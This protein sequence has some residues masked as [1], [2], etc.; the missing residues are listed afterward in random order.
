VGLCNPLGRVFVD[1]EEEMS[2]KLKAG[3]IGLGILGSKH[4]QALVENPDV[5]LVAVA[6]LRRNVAD[7][8]AKQ[9]VAEAYYDYR[10]MLVEHRLD[11]VVVATPDP[12]HRE[13]AMAALDAGVPNLIME[14]PLATTLE[15]AT[16]I[17]EKAEAKKA[18]LFINFSNRAA[19]N[20]IATR[21]VV[22]Q[23][24]LGKVVYGDVR[25]DD[26]ISVPTAMWGT[27]TEEWA[28]GS[29][30]AQF[31]LSHV[32][33]ILR[34]YMAPAEVTDVFA[35]SQRE[36]LKYTPDLY[37][38]YLTWDS[39]ARVRVK[40]EWIRHMD[41]LVEFYISLSGSE[42]T[43]IYNKRPGFAAT[44]GWRANLRQDLTA[45]DL[46]AHQNKLLELGANVGALLHRPRPSTG[47]L[48]AG[49]G[50]LVPS[51]EHRGDV[52]VSPTVLVP[53]FVNAILQDTLTPTGAEHLGPL[54]NYVDGWR[55]SQVVAAIVRSAEKGEPVSL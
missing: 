54:P 24:L 33:D 21:Y 2:A 6:D 50:A 7:E 34:W 49:G 53:H 22:Q 23:G 48:S 40:A 38:A 43:L 45:A 15:D 42:G 18:H 51:L 29:S 1:K 8:V 44:P 9:A 20:D 32:V 36:V 35:M 16:A 26:N 14:K 27:R 31:L 4:V 25:L 13:P 19:Q 5:K 39:G 30:T 11:L 37:D 46:V 28:A 52:T 17:R 12:L 10:A 47:A 41:E 3:V 55:Q